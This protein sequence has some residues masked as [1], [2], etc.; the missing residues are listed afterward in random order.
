MSR[1]AIGVLIFPGMTLARAVFV[2]FAVAVSLIQVHVSARL[3]TGLTE[4]AAEASAGVARN[5]ALNNPGMASQY[6]ANRE[7]SQ[8]LADRESLSARA[9][10]IF[11]WICGV[12]G[13]LWVLA[14]AIWDLRFLA[15]RREVKP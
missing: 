2:S 5:L 13:S 9:W 15:A 7:R 11:A 14:C 4:L 10:L 6:E 12:G 3:A 1:R 8:R